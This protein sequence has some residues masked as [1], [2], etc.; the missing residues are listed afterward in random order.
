M[1]SPRRVPELS[2][3]GQQSP[4]RSA[5]RRAPGAGK[6]PS[7]LEQFPQA[8]PASRSRW[9]VAGGEVGEKHGWEAVLSTM[10]AWGCGAGTRQWQGFGSLLVSDQLRSHRQL[11]PP[12]LETENPT[13]E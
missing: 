12:S 3:P 6:K 11:A 13:R 8:H 9:R 10:I 5:E 2:R 7:R 4:A 1:A